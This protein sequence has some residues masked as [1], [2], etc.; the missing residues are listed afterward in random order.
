MNTDS[1][2]GS[3]PA[4]QL[5]SKQDEGCGGCV[6]PGLSACICWMG[7]LPSAHMLS[8]PPATTTL[9]APSMMD[10]APSMSAFMPAMQC[11]GKADQPIRMSA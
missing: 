6:P 5:G 7:A 4:L 8:M 2:T 10:C 3:A 1:T 11:R 9:L